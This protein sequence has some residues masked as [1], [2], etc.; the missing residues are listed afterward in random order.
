[1]LL[2]YALEHRSR[3][4]VLLFAAAC[5]ASSAYGF[6]AGTWPF[7]VVEAVWTAVA[8]QRWARREARGWE[9]GRRPIACDMTAL[10]ATERHRYNSLR[11]RVLEALEGAQETRTGFLLRMDTSVSFSEVAEWAEMELLLRA[12]GATWIQIGGSAAIEAF[13]K[14]EFSAFRLEP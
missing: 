11:R 6:L 4:F 1:M 8:L 12:D 5:T 14:E 2:A 7:G 3:A 9:K 13:L 10:S